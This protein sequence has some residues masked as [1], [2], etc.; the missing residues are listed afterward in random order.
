MIKLGIFHLLVSVSSIKRLNEINS[1]R[2]I[3]S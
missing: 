2:E 1:L 3:I